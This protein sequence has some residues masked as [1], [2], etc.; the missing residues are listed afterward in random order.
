MPNTDGSAPLA[1]SEQSVLDALRYAREPELRRDLVGLDLVRRI[2][3]SGR[4]VRVVLA[5][6]VADDPIESVIVAAA[7]SAIADRTTAARIDI[8]VQPLDDD[9]QRLLATRLRAD[10]QPHERAGEGGHGHAADRPSRQVS[11]RSE[12]RPG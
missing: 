9:E 8:S 5:T 10:D 3:V 6:K 12:A 2:E 11:C 4:D 7:R 1:V